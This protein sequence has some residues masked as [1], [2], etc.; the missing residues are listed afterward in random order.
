MALFQLE[1]DLESVPVTSLPTAP[2]YL[3]RIKL[4]AALPFL[5]T[6]DLEATLRTSLTAIVFPSWDTMLPPGLRT[7]CWGGGTLKA[8]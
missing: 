6:F 1:I 3:L 5:L 2:A 4:K 8:L 7:D